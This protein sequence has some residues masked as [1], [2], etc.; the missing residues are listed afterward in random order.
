MV[1]R[2]QLFRQS[3]KSGAF[4]GWVAEDPEFLFVRHSVV[5]DEAGHLVCVTLGPQGK[6]APSGIVIHRP[7]WTLKPF[8][9]LPA[10]V[11]VFPPVE[12]P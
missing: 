10:Q 1:L 11:Q 4:E 5:A 3:Q 12:R 7:E 2:R 6:S 8:A 9:E